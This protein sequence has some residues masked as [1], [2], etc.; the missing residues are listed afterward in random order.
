MAHRSPPT[1]ESPAN[2]SISP[3]NWSICPR[4]LANLPPTGQSAANWS[5]CPANW[6]I[7][8]QLVNF[9][10][11][12]RA[13]LPPGPRA[14]ARWRAPPAVAGGTAGRYNPRPGAASWRTFPGGGRQVGGPIAGRQGWIYIYVC[15]YV[16]IYIYRGCTST[17]G[18]P[19]TNWSIFVPSPPPTGQSAANPSIFSRA[20][21]PAAN[22]RGVVT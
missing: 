22:W 4:Q 6:R 20:H 18:P 8:R 13:S 12:P 16:C 2:W 15:M 5:I 9:F 1:G 3:A 14:G 21:L 10:F 11:P 7:F 17:D 19:P